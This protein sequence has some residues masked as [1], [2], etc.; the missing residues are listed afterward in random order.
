MTSFKTR[1]F[2]VG[3][4]AQWLGAL[5]L[6]KTQVL[7]PEPTWWLTTV[8]NYSLTP[9]WAPGS[10]GVESSMAKGTRSERGQGWEHEAR[11]E[12]ETGGDGEGHTRGLGMLILK[13]TLP[14]NSIL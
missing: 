4:T 7:F 14:G 8:H 1:I 9:S 13:A 5:F 11:A 6:Q 10:G 12:P 3:D 2:Q